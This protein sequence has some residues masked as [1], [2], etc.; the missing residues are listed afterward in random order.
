MVPEVCGEKGVYHTFELK[1]CDS[2]GYTGSCVT[3]EHFGTVYVGQSEVIRFYRGV[4][5]FKGTP[6][7]RHTLCLINAG[8]NTVYSQ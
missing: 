8:S 3:S 1:G 5:H 6:E 7:L 2:S 4:T